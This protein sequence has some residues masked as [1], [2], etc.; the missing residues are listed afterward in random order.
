MTII[1]KHC[2]NLATLKANIEK[3]IRDRETVTIGGGDFSGDELQSLLWAV[4]EEMTRAKH[5]MYSPPV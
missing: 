3:A 2:T 5:R 1:L 4:R